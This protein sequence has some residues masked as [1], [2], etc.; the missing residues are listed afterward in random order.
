M[1]D[2][3]C[4]RRFSIDTI[5]VLFL[6]LDG[7]DY[8]GLSYE[9]IFNENSVNPYRV[10]IPILNSICLEYDEYFSVTLTTNV[11]NVT[12]VNDT[13]IIKIMNDDCKP[14]YD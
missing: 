12:L 2:Q 8:Q 14:S 6:A 4:D 7:E 11:D 10:Y 13:V 1:K 3:V 9:V 5:Y